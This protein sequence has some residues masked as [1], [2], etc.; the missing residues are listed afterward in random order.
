LVFRGCCHD[1]EPLDDVEYRRIGPFPWINGGIDY[2]DIAGIIA[3][4]D[5]VVVIAC[6]AQADT[7]IRLYRR[8]RLGFIDVDTGIVGIIA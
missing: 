2:I 6:S 8:V 1:L 4:I 5:I 7:W 3:I